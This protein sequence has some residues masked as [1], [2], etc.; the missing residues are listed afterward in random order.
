MQP[1]PFQQ[2][3]LQ[4]YEVRKSTYSN[5]WK[6]D[7]M[8][9]TCASPLWCLF[10]AC[11]PQCAS[12]ML[13]K[14]ALYNDMN[15]YVC[16][17][18]QCPCSG[19]MKEQECP[20][21]CLAAE[22]C[23]CFTQSVASTRWMI[24]DEMRIQNTQC[25]NCLIGCMIAMQYVACLCNIAAC[26]SG[27]DELGELAHCTDNIAQ[28]AW[29]SVCACMQAQHK[30][31][32]DERDGRG[33]PPPPNPLQ[34]PGVQMMGPSAYAGP[35]PGGPQGGPPQ[36]YP[37]GYPQQGGYPQQQPP[38]QGYYPQQPGLSPQGTPQQMNRY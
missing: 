4:A 34:A 36:G 18:G 37:Q 32:L 26:L 2:Q 15:R 6:T 1:T 19:R 29:C 23:F 24:Q 3:K 16:C 33:A 17:A 9:A 28:V 31:Q 22:V 5:T 27:N 13:R 21:V 12:Y 35:P 10:G 25:D 20:E 38:P 30:V 8:G 11:C 14:Q 7:L